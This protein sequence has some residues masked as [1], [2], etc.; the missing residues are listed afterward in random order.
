[1]SLKWVPGYRGKNMERWGR[2]DVAG[3]PAKLV[4]DAYIQVNASI[5]L[6]FTCNFAV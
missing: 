5:R 1:M 3:Q 6:S 4:N 2:H